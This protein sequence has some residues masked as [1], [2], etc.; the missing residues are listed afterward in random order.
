MATDVV[1]MHPTGSITITNYKKIQE[2]GELLRV[3]HTDDHLYVFRVWNY[4][5]VTTR[6]DELIGSL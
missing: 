2:D 1:V 5:E 3:I 6:K 4:Y